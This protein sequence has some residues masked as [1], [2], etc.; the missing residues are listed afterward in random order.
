MPL[1]AIN[2]SIRDESISSNFISDVLFEM[3]ALSVSISDLNAGQPDEELIFAEPPAT[4]EQAQTVRAWSKS[5]I[6]ALYPLSVDVQS[7]IMIIGTQFNLHDTP[8]FSI[9]TEEFD[10]KTPAEWVRH[11]QA[12]FK[13]ILLANNRLRISFPWHEPP[14]LDLIDV[15]LEPGIAFG[16]GEHPTTQLCLSWL[17]KAVRPNYAVLD[18]GSGSGVLA[19]AACLLAPN[20]SATGVDIDPSVIKVA[21]DNAKLN[22]VSEQV[23]FQ[24]NSQFSSPPE[25]FDL[26]VANILANPLMQLADLLVSNVKKGG[27]IAMSGLLVSQAP[28]IVEH[29]VKHGITLHDV[30]VTSGWVLLVG[31]KH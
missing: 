30:E 22:N 31:V 16:T 6:T 15:R 7:L 21:V 11:V 18:F 13:P 25:Q 10:E 24:E 20:V 14:S 19:I 2:I 12:S 3:G 9:N 8:T 4:W 28:L 5:R 29:Y 27:F 1:N 26:V 23:F 17:A